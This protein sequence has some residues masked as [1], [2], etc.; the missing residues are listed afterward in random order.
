M[1]YLFGSD[2]L[3]WN[4]L[5]L[6][7][8]QRSRYELKYIVIDFLKV[9]WIQSSPPPWS[10]SRL[11]NVIVSS[12]LPSCENNAFLI[13]SCYVKFY[14]IFLFSIWNFLTLIFSLLK[15]QKSFHI[16][17]ITINQFRA[18]VLKLFSW[19]LYVFKNYW[20]PQS[21]FDY[22]TYLLIFNLL[23]VKARKNIKTFC[24]LIH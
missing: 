6:C 10:S 5:K 1:K 17:L 19:P 21:I 18:A 22:M 12:L 24:L 7:H 23:G 14:N 13:Q 11:T 4:L 9:K 8:S 3:F 2:F 16:F 20:A 15:K